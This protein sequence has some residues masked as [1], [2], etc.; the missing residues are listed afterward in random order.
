MLKAVDQIESVLSRILSRSE[1][2]IANNE[3][4]SSVT[5]A[6]EVAKTAIAAAR[7]AIQEQT[8]KVYSVEATTE[9]ALKTDLGRVRD[10]LRSDLEAVKSKVKAARDAVQSAA[11]S[12]AQIP[13]VDELEVSSQPAETPTSSDAAGTVEEGSEVELSEPAVQ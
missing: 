12:L 9:E 11:V 2:A 6:S 13:K 1:K 10:M 8:A 4:V 3:N 5:T 7:T